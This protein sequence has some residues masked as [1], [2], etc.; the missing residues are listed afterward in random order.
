MALTFR[1]SNIPH[2]V[3]GEDLLKNLTDI[4]PGLSAVSEN[5]ICL[6]SIAPSPFDPT[7]EQVAIVTFNPV[8]SGLQEAKHGSQQKQI[9]MMGVSTS[10][11]L[12]NFDSHFIDLAPLNDISSN[13]SLE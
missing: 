4:F 13:A 8:P 11:F 9:R 7:K 2:G 1:I 10:S 3:S 12:A 6:R 5:S